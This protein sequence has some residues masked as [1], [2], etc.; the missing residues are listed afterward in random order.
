MIKTV[1]CVLQNV[2]SK[3]RLYLPYSKH[4]NGTLKEF[5]AENIDREDITGVDAYLKSWS[6]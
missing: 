5:K 2:L 6:W 3:F 1:C 4:D